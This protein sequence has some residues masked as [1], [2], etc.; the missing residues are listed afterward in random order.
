MGTLKPPQPSPPH[1]TPRIKAPGGSAPLYRI[2]RRS[3]AV[4]NFR[5]DGDGVFLD[6]NVSFHPLI[7]KAWQRGHRVPLTDRNDVRWIVGDSEIA[8]RDDGVPPQSLFNLLCV[9]APPP[10]Q[11]CP[12]RTKLRAYRNTPPYHDIIFF[13]M[14]CLSAIVWWSRQS[15]DSE[16]QFTRSFCRIFIVG[17]QN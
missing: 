7:W 10:R 3:P 16:N 14:Y 13:M 6:D 12:W 17:A 11:C 5:L 1:S 8:D 4:M 9:A 2:M 15:N